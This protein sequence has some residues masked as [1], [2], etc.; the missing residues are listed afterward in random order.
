M[1]LK[2]QRGHQFNKKKKKVRD[3]RENLAKERNAEF[4]GANNAPMAISMESTVGS[5]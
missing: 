5:C 1:I 4:G 2:Q 3:N